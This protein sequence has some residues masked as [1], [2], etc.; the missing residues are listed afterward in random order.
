MCGHV[1]GDPYGWDGIR[2]DVLVTRYDASGVRLWTE[3]LSGARPRDPETETLGQ[4][5]QEDRVAAGPFLTPYSGSWTP[6]WR[7]SLLKLPSARSA[8]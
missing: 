5:A 6:A 4:A 1:D 7:G 2:D 8:G 3:L